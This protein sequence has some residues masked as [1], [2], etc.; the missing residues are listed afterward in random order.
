MKLCHPALLRDV[1]I[2]IER[3]IA[4]YGEHRKWIS[5]ASVCKL[6]NDYWTATSAKF[7]VD[8][9]KKAI[10]ELQ[11]IDA[12]ILDGRDTEGILVFETTLPNPNQEYAPRFHGSMGSYDNPTPHR[13]LKRVFD[14]LPL[15]HRTFNPATVAEELGYSPELVV[16]AMRELRLMNDYNYRWSSPGFTTVTKK[17][18]QLGYFTYELALGASVSI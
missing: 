9:I 10:R 18:L 7:T 3:H 16:K 5:Y 14:A 17:R 8:D 11:A 15:P 6:V 13:I 1:A 12:L 2:A 4:A